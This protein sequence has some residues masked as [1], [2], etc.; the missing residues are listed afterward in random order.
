MLTCAKF[1]SLT[2]RLSESPNSPIISRSLHSLLV[3]LSTELGSLETIS[4]DLHRAAA[5][6]EELGSSL[7][8]TLGIERHHLSHELALSPSWKRLVDRGKRELV[9][10]ELSKAEMV[11]RDVELTRDTIDNLGTLRGKL[12]QT[13]R[14][15]KLFRD[16]VSEFDASIMGFHLGTDDAGIPLEEEIMV[17]NRVVQSLDGSVKQ[18]KARA[19]V[20]W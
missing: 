7:I 13:R 17:L 19:S 6:T 12:D 4:N 1:E 16:Q 8:E 9:G 15:V 5:H 20:G 2:R 14:Q 18:A 3:R 11:A 10:G